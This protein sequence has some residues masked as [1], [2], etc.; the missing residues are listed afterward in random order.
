VT[1][2][3]QLL[4]SKLELESLKAEVDSLKGQ[5][6]SCR[7]ELQKSRA[8]NADSQSRLVDLAIKTEL[9]ESLKQDFDALTA[10]YNELYSVSAELDS[11]LQTAQR[12]LAEASAR[13]ERFQAQASEAREAANDT[14]SKL[15][16]RNAEFA[17]LESRIAA[18]EQVLKTL[19]AENSQL[20]DENRNLAAAFSS[21]AEE[22]EKIGAELKARTDA[23]QERDGQNA[24]QIDQLTKRLQDIT[25]ECDSRARWEDDVVDLLRKAAGQGMLSICTSSDEKPPDQLSVASLRG[26]SAEKGTQSSSQAQALVQLSSLIV[27]M[28]QLMEERAKLSESSQTEAKAQM[29]KYNAEIQDLARKLGEARSREALAQG[30]E[31]GL[32]QA[33]QELKRRVRELQAKMSSQTRKEALLERRV[34]ELTE[35]REAAATEYRQ[36]LRDFTE[37]ADKRSRE[38]EQKDLEQKREISS[39]RAS[40]EAEHARREQDASRSRVAGV[41]FL[42]RRGLSQLGG[43][44]SAHPVSGHSSFLSRDVPKEQGPSFS[45][46]DS[47]PAS[48]AAKRPG[49]RPRNRDGARER[50]AREPVSSGTKRAGQQSGLTDDS[51]VERQMDEEDREID[52]LLRRYRRRRLEGDGIEAAV[53]S[54][55]L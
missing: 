5:L 11:D 28:H 45:V 17:K 39:L 33:I 49:S 50:P 40:L 43:Q 12:N 51:D 6:S 15:A 24:L 54:A 9:C 31:A 18:T 34:A 21:A 8:E 19:G 1:L 37:E 53:D 38:L 55:L 10:R 4:R 48:R 27:G 44:G 35:M 14:G 23:W 7:A 42:D 30:K 25:D 52:R 20:Q 36:K 2:E 13:A 22:A 32:M 26:P 16:A 46:F 47:A 29:E 3:T 41:S